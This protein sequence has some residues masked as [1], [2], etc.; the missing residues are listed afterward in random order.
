VG[1][2]RPDHQPR[3]RR[4]DAGGGRIGDRGDLVARPVAWLGLAAV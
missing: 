4:R 3:R 2:G 1:A